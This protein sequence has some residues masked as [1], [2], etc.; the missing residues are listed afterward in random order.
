MSSFGNLMMKLNADKTQMVSAEDALPGSSEPR[1]QV[2]E[3]HAVLG[4]PLKPPFPEGIEVAYF[5]ARE[6]EL[7]YTTDEA[8]NDGSAVASFLGR[9][10]S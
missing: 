7:Y 2:P 3:T 6:H 5:R 8:K 4:T 1:F 9:G 10:G